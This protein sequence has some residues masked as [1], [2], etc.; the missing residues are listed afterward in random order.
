[1]TKRTKRATVVTVSMRFLFWGP[2]KSNRIGR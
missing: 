1:M 2:S